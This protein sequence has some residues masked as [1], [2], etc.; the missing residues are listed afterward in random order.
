ML[1]QSDGGRC[2]TCYSVGYNFKYTNLQAAMGL[3]QL[4]TL[5][6]RTRAK[7]NNRLY[8]SKLKNIKNLKILNFDYSNGEVPLWTDVYVKR[9]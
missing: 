8:R 5:A 3:A 6:K 4:D 2:K 7:K 9:K 1:G